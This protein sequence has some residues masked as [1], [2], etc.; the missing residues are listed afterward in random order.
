MDLFGWKLANTVCLLEHALSFIANDQGRRLRSLAFFMLF[1]L[2]VLLPHNMLKRLVG[3]LIRQF[4]F[5]TF[6]FCSLTMLLWRFFSSD[7]T[8]LRN[9][10][11]FNDLVNILSFGYGCCLVVETHKAHLLVHA[12]LI[13]LRHILLGRF[14]F[15]PASKYLL[16]GGSFICL[17]GVVFRSWFGYVRSI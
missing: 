10:T 7:A 16:S 3:S 4:R 6:S 5:S 8:S 1:I 14:D 9:E 2:L 12:C 17:P 11:V 15:I 13:G